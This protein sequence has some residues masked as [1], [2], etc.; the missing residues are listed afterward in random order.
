[1]R[2]LL[3]TAGL[4]VLLATPASVFAQKAYDHGEVEA[5]GDLFRIA[6]SG[7]PAVNYLGL[8]GRLSIN[9]GTF[10]ALKGR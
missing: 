5:Y 4:A 9:T 8:G 6:P 3:V 10:L 2:H 7:V 1:M